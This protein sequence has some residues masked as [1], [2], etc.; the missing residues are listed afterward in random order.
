MKRGSRSDRE[1]RDGESRWIGRETGRM[2]REY[3]VMNDG[4]RGSRMEYGV[5]FSRTVLAP[6]EWG[7]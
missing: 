7:K 5:K 1:R 4:D 2:G 6:I 3:V